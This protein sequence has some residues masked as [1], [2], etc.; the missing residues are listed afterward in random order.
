M[1]EEARSR[2]CPL[3]HTSR[4]A[5]VPCSSLPFLELNRR[6]DVLVLL[7]TKSQPGSS[8]P[9]LF[10][11]SRDEAV[12]CCRHPY[13][14]FKAG[15][16][17]GKADLKPQA[18]KCLAGPGVAVGWS[19]RWSLHPLKSQ[20]LFTLPF[21]TAAEPGAIPRCFCRRGRGMHGHSSQPWTETG[22][23]TP[24]VDTIQKAMSFYLFF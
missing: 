19:S 22:L 11:Q 5:G 13:G 20:P 24:G 18:V 21:L 7:Q 14:K 3:K 17:T 12:P 15:R 1:H 2:S 8:S 23:P 9:F 6:V 16:Q 4:V 10:L